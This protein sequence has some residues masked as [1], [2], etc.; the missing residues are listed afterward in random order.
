MR[1]FVLTVAFLAVS[2]TVH[3]QTLPAYVGKFPLQL[4]S[5]LGLGQTPT[6]P[7]PPVATLRFDQGVCSVTTAAVITPSAQANNCGGA[8][9]PSWI[10]NPNTNYCLF[11][12]G[13]TSN[14]N[15][16]ATQGGA[17][18]VT[19]TAIAAQVWAGP[20]IYSITGRFN[21]TNFKMIA[22]SATVSVYLSCGY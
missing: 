14:L 18:P 13:S 11:S 17:N 15:W 10:T 5:L 8:G 4:A 20:G 16:N 22:A 7:G 12:V 2:A 21:L 1:R 6:P 9:T 19:G 3:A